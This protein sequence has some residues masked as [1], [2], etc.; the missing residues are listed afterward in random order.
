MGLPGAVALP[1]L[2]DL[3]VRALAEAQRHVAALAGDACLEIV[4]WEGYRSHETQSYLYQDQLKLVRQR[5][6]DLCES[7]LHAL[8]E[9]RVEDP[10]RVF[11][12]GTGGAV[13][14]TLSS[15]ALLIEMGSSYGDQ[16]DRSRRDFYAQHLPETPVDRRASYHR[17]LLRAAM[18]KAGF[19]SDEAAWW[20]FELGTRLWAR[21][22][23][24]VALLDR[25][26]PPPSPEGPSARPPT[27]PDRYPSWQSGVSRPFLSVHESAQALHSPTRGHYYARISH[28]GADAL[29]CLLSREVFD[30]TRT[31]LSSS[32]L[33]AC[34]Q[35]V[36]ALM[37]PGRTLLYA[38]DVY[39]QCKLAFR[40]EAAR[41]GWR[42]QQTASPLAALAGRDDVGLVYVDS[43]SNWHLNCY[44]LCC[45]AAAAHD[46]QALLVVDVTL[47]PCQEA[48]SK[49]ADA[50]VCSLSKDISLG[51]TTAGA[52]ASSNAVLMERVASEV[53]ASG[54]M[55]TAETTH[56][57]Y[58]H[59]VS[60]R[61][62]LYAHRAKVQS[63][64][65]MLAAQASVASV[66]TADINLC[67]GLT[68]SQLAVRLRD[69][70]QGSR[71]ERLV[72]QRSLDPAAALHLGS[73]FG[74]VY[75]SVEHFASRLGPRGD[76]SGRL[77][78]PSDLVRIGLGCEQ[79]DR[80]S[81][82]LA[83]VLEASRVATA[84]PM[85]G[86]GLSSSAAP[87]TDE[88]AVG[89]LR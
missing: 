14:V 27:V 80:I 89:A 13:A 16:S 2:A 55:V 43:P 81:A 53:A 60:V 6:P 24:R 3:A 82:D 26:L 63:V 21:E 85:P 51:H 38:D 74:A 33:S 22:K 25:V 17:R 87:A 72:G 8:V 35:A 62:R 88:I 23:G 12:Y 39:H 48:L 50:V 28:P 19:A 10:D 68:S 52:I 4:L 56:I 75:T 31:I 20:H 7:E 61:D 1:F 40:R 42:A 78:I 18:E 65:D 30:S 49:G 73:T 77:A 64:S 32:G 47:Q 54:Q 58:Q 67:G 36:V 15:G 57:I 76:G 46:A 69:P 86:P 5:N 83:F 59:A 44:D 37:E 70:G 66:R 71:L 34:I 41:L 9:E 79:V 11:A 84:V 45:L 29:T